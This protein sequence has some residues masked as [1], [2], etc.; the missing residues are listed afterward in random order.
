LE[1][2]N[3]SYFLQSVSYLNIKNQAMW[4]S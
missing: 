4:P 1:N 2:P 3:G